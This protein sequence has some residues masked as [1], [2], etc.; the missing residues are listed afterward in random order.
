MTKYTHQMNT[1]PGVL[2]NVQSGHWKYR[3]LSE[4]PGDTMHLSPIPT[5]N[6][7]INLNMI[8]IIK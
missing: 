7:F 5:P 6:C 2:V 8:N 4:I 3:R 1:C